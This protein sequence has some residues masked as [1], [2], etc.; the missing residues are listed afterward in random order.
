MVLMYMKT[1]KIYIHHLLTHPQPNHLN[2]QK[3]NLKIIACIK[4]MKCNVNNQGKIE[5][6]YN[7]PS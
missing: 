1:S 3:K 2:F 7:P 4:K 5:R 6:L